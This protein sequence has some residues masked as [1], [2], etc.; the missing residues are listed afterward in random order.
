VQTLILGLWLFLREREEI[1]KVVASWRVSALVGLTSMAGSLGWFIAFTLQ[2]AALVKAVGQVE[3]VFT[4]L[5]SIFWLKERSSGKEIAGIA[6]ILVSLG[7]I[8][9]GT[10]L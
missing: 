6:L 7:I 5:F 9:A 2:T 1:G 4:F 10:L 8:I 3:L